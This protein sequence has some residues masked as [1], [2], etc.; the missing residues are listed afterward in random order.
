MPTYNLRF[1][2]AD[3]RLIFGTG[4]GDEAVYG[5]P[6]VADVLAT[7]VDNGIGTEADFLTDDNRSE[8]ATAT[9]VDGGTTTTGLIDAEE[10]WLVRDTVTG[11]TIRVVRVDTVGDDY[12]LTSAPLV[13]GRAYETIGYD[14]LPADNDGF[15]F[16]YAEF[17]DGIV[18]GTNGDDVIDRDYTGDPNGDVV[19][20]NDQMGTGRQEG[21]FQW[22]DYGTGTDLSGS[23]TQVSGDVEV[24][25][26]TG[27]AA[28]TTFT[29][30]DT[31]IFVPGDVDI[32]SDSS[33]WL[34]ANG[35]QADSTLQIDF[36]AAQGADVT[37]EVQ[38]VRFLITDIDGV[39]DAANNFQD[40]VTVLAFDAEGNAVEVALTALGN[41]SVSGNTVT[42]LIDS[43][44]GFQADGA[45]LVQIDGPV[46]RI[47]LI[48]DNGGNTQQAVYVSDIHFATVQT[49]GNADS[50]EAGAGNDSVFAGSDDD[51][52]D[53]GVGNDTLD[54]GSGDDSLIGG[55]GRDLIE[56]GTGDDTAFGEGGND[57]LSG[58]AGNDSLDGGG[59][60]DSLLGG[61]G[62]D[63]LIGGNGSDT[64]EGGEGADSLDG[65]IG[66]DQ[67][68]GGAENDT[69]DG[70]NGTDTLS[71]GTGDD[72]IL[73]G[74]GDDTLSGGDGADTLDGGNNSDVLSGGAG[75]DVLS[76]GTG[77]DT[78]DGGAGADVLDGGD[79]DDSLTVGGGDT[80]TGGEGD[81]LFIL[82]P[83]AL[84]GDPIT[85][86]GG[87]T[88]E[89]AG[90]TLDFN[91]QLLQ[92]S[93]VYSNT[94]DAAGGFSGTAELLDGTIVTFSEIE[95][96]I[97][98]VA[99][100]RIATPHG[101]RAVETL[102]EGDL[103]LTR[104][105]GLRP[106]RWTGR[107]DV[108]AR[109]SQAPVTI[110]AGG[111]WGNRRDLRVS[112]MH[113][114]LVA[115]WRAQLLFGEPEVLVPAHVLVDGE[116]ILRADAS[117]RITYHHL[118][119]DDHEVILAEDV[120]CE[121]FLGGDEALRG[122]D[123][124]DRA[125]LIA[126]RP[127]LACGCGL[128]PARTLPKPAHARALAVA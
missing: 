81:D 118:M 35:N 43:D 56:G 49:G 32:A 77:R 86:V 53:G 109:A 54:G 72:L 13:E 106:I 80:A 107:R 47:E 37:G 96:I 93:I 122:L 83:A 4:V 5:G 74:G 92:G 52:V 82:D 46:A 66:S 7:V 27:L 112:P 124:A 10:A 101:P 79:G 39:V 23:Q 40:I 125:R 14:G 9:I 84:D 113:R 88:G 48:Y 116:R 50:I 98:F 64:L 58:G 36:A 114:L 57:T 91:G 121:S 33:A 16:A 29:A 38:D 128:R 31:T 59:N 20:G 41:D 2:G 90:D 69:L 104:D 18:T 120:P 126:L 22:S 75:D 102:R 26:T 103:V 45:A 115:D 34:F 110:R 105:A 21:S 44:E 71:G 70:G 95:T 63:T 97:C 28:G 6:S 15:G 85:I 100:T 24:T 60:S 89:T 94:D 8:T 55:G 68:D 87:E 123:P 99:G 61:E 17:N 25:V 62:D 30:T 51:T 67:L 111:I 78:L 76:G 117:E 127:D 1:Y 42:A 65:G 19:D 108:A 11:E 73:G 119:L 3:P 12:M